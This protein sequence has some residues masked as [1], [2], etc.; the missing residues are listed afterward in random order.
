MV[1]YFSQ[2][3]CFS[4]LSHWEQT[5][6]PGM[7]ASSKTVPERSQRRQDA[8]RLV[9]LNLLT[10]MFFCNGER[11]LTHVGAHASIDFC[12]SMR[13]GISQLAYN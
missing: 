8:L 3:H 9:T 13:N 2:V 4:V 6:G 10:W 7:G 1:Q 11:V 5:T 12:P